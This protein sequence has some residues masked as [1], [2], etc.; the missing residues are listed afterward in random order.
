MAEFTQLGM[1][2][3]LNPTPPSTK[4][5][6]K[7][8][9]KEAVGEIKAP[10]TKEVKEEVKEE[11]KIERPVSRKAAHRDK[12]QEAQGRVR[13]PE[14]GQYAAKP[15]I[16]E[17]PAKLD[18]KKEPVKEEP[19]KEPAKTAA[20]QQ[21]LTDKEKAFLR[22]MQEERGKRQELEK[23]LAAL[24][25]P[26]KD[27]EDAPKTFWDDPEANLAKHEAKIR[28]EIT[29]ARLHTSEMIARK[30]HPD[31][32]EKAAIFG[33]L[34]RTAPGLY[35]QWMKEIDPAEFA[36]Q[37][38]KNHMEIRDAGNIDQLRAKIE[39]ETRLKLEQELKEKAEA[40]AKEKAAIPPSLGDAAGKAAN[41]VV[42]GGP[43]PM[44]QILSEK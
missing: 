37:T 16:K 12:E 28:G 8:A 6:V 23:R 10:E 42:W 29:A 39:K 7:E 31:F 18:E 4:E 30:S 21:D 35:E 44:D 22:A 34:L 11:V 36:Y 1:D 41:K 40:L 26:K 24:E 17:E 33:E 43:T 15:E 19:V 9:V 3:I 27:T 13:D 25:T 5:V 32:G 38:G 2:E 14:T 20:P